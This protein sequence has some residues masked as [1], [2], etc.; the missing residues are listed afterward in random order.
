MTR[1]YSD[2]NKSKP[3]HEAIAEKLSKEFGGTWSFHTNVDKHSEM[4][5]LSYHEKNCGGKVYRKVDEAYARDGTLIDYCVA[6]YEQVSP[7]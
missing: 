7:P 6:I 4:I 5:N 2:E 1:S 3:L